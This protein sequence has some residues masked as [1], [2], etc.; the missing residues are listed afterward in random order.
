[1][2]EFLLYQYAENPQGNT[3]KHFPR[4]INWK[5][6]PV[7]ICLPPSV[8]EFILSL[9]FF[10]SLKKRNRYK[11]FSGGLDRGCLRGRKWQ[12]C[13]RRKYPKMHYFITSRWHSRWWI[14][15]GAG[16]G[17]PRG[18]HVSDASDEMQGY[19]QHGHKILSWGLNTCILSRGKCKFLHRRR[20]YNSV[21][22]TSLN[23]RSANFSPWATKIMN[24]KKSY[25]GGLC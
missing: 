7:H 8:K 22:V 18:H 16:G 23:Q 11:I 25:L 3:A 2:H 17:G 12:H 4:F 13:S 20:W 1:M 9:F 24:K 10:F 5:Y 6:V 21:Y 19:M 14:T 15:H